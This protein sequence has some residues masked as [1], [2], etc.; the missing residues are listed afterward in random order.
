MK[1]H[2]NV[3]STPPTQLPHT[4]SYIVAILIH[5]HFEST[6]RI[7]TKKMGKR[8]FRFQSGTNKINLPDILVGKFEET[9]R[10]FLH[11]LHRYYF[12]ISKKSLEGKVSVPNFRTVQRTKLQI[13]SKSF[14]KHLQNEVKNL[15]S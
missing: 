14:W 7:L 15:C 9:K 5:N 13:N 10:K 1:R 3:N 4:F 11:N 2:T 8:K 12:T 6:N